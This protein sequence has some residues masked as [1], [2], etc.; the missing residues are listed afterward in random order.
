MQFI[1][2]GLDDGADPID[3]NHIPIKLPT[4]I[5]KV[6]VKLLPANRARLLVPF[7]DVVAGIDRRAGFGNLGLYPKYIIGLLGEWSARERMS[8]MS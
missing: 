4:F 8:E 2:K 5:S 3:G 6:V 1:P 7:V